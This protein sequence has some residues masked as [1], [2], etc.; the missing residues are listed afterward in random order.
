MKGAGR[1]HQD[2]EQA[3]I[4]CSMCIYNSLYGYDQ[5]HREIIEKRLA[6]SCILLSPKDALDSD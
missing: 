3:S 2:N 1:Y 6:A 4:K 5:D